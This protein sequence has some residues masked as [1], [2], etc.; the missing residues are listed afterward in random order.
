MNVKVAKG[1]V[2]FG[3]PF[4]SSG[5]ICNKNGFIIGDISGGPEIQN[6]DE[7]LGFLNI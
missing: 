3:S 4:I 6:A 1:S 7:A 5:L 2:N